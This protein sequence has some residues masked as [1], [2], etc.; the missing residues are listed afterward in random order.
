MHCN[1]CLKEYH[2]YCVHPMC[3]F[4]EKFPNQTYV[5]PNCIQNN[6]SSFHHFASRAAYCM[7]D[8]SQ[9]F[10]KEQYKKWSTFSSYNK[11]NT[12]YLT[13]RCP[14]TYCILPTQEQMLVKS[15]NYFSYFNNCYM[16]VIVQ[17]LL[18][19]VVQR[20]IPSI[21]DNPSEVVSALD[22]CQKTIWREQ[23]QQR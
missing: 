23:E 9:D 5:C 14:T 3:N 21:S 22:S 18:G 13:C 15:K 10:I 16:L 2:P 8:F 20:V 1:L 4:P 19:T 17:S 7:F 6:S 12:R 11:I